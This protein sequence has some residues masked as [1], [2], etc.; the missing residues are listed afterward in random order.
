M[1]EICS[2]FLLLPVI[3]MHLKKY[4]VWVL[5]SAVSLLPSISSC[6]LK[7]LPLL[8][9]LPHPIGN[10]SYLLYWK[11]S[12][13]FSPQYKNPLMVFFEVIIFYDLWCGVGVPFTIALPLV[14]RG[15][16][17]PH[18]D[19]LKCTSWICDLFCAQSCSKII[20]SI[21]YLK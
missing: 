21:V 1:N 12:S 11:K 10:A 4:L 9:N 8:P 14:C 3:N 19:I 17:D 6:I 15:A 13:W 20:G 7:L 16:L 5:L 2:F 18:E